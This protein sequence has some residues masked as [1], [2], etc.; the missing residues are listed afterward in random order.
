MSLALLLSWYLLGALA[1]AWMIQRGHAPTPWWV[2][3]ALLGALLWMIALPVACVVG[4]RVR[5]ATGDPSDP[6]AGP[7]VVGLLDDDGAVA[8]AAANVAGPDDVFV[9]VRRVGFEATGRAVD[10]GELARATMA[11]EAAERRWSGT[12]L[13]RVGSGPLLDVV[14]EAVPRR[15]RLVVR[16]PL[17]PV[18]WRRDL[19]RSVR[20]GSVS[21]SPV[22]HAPVAQ[23]RPVATARPTVGSAA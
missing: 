3:A 8:S 22:L 12:M 16:G 18:A 5:W 23:R 21:G 20:L 9:A 2:G 14:D 13:A 11:A 1:A 6:P 4:R 19:R 15:P 17:A 10:T 7:V